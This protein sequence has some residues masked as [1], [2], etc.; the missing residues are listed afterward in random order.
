[1]L[2]PFAVQYDHFWAKWVGCKC[3][4]CLWLMVRLKH[5]LTDMFDEWDWSLS[6]V[7]T[8]QSKGLNLIIFNTAWWSYEPD[9]FTCYIGGL[10]ML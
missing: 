2:V 8:I 3:C 7:Q 10:P 1:M 5:M 4:L 6:A 9:N